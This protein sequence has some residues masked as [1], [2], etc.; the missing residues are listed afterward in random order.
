MI[1]E[2]P[3]ES[4]LDLNTKGYIMFLRSMT[5][6]VSTPTGRSAPQPVL[7]SVAASAARPASAAAS[8]ARPILTRA[9]GAPLTPV[10]ATSPVLVSWKPVSIIAVPK[11]DASPTHSALP[12]VF[13]KPKYVTPL[14]GPRQAAPTISITSTN[15]FT[16]AMATN[17]SYD[18]DDDDF[19]E[20]IAVIAVLDDLIEDS[21]KQ[22]AIAGQSN[23]SSS[24]SFNAPFGNSFH[25]LGLGICGLLVTGYSIYTLLNKDGS[26]PS[27]DSD[28]HSTPRMGSR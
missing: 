4:D 9:T 17:Q 2:A 28:V 18:D 10:S 25:S 24:S 12:S 1:Y 22:R 5:S 13:N 23:K 20:K 7:A 6:Q 3:Q 8:A 11:S 14:A 16:R 27:M 19:V 21:A 15:M 26:S